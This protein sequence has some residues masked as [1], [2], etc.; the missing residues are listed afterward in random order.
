MFSRLAAQLEGFLAVNSIIFVGISFVIHKLK[1][2]A[3]RSSK[4]FTAVMFSKSSP[5]IIGSTNV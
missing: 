3:W 4:R 1:R 2:P 5:Q